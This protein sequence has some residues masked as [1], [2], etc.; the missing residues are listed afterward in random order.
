[1]NRAR[2]GRRILAQRRPTTGLASL[3]C[4]AV[5]VIEASLLGGPTRDARDRIAHRVSVATLA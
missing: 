5:L 1:M 4:R 2:A 3:A